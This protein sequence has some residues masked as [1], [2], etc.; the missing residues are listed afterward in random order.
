MN[1]SPGAEIPSLNRLLDI[2]SG[3]HFGDPQQIL[4]IWD[5][6]GAVIWE[7]GATSAADQGNG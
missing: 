7:R 5:C 3:I 6:P 2:A 1:A 4:A